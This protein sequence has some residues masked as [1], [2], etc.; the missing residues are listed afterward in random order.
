MLPLNEADAAILTDIVDGTLS[1]PEWDAWLAA[2]PRAAAELALARRVRFFMQELAAASIAVPPGFEA[3]LLARV[4]AD[5]A[6]RDLL[7]LGLTALGRAVLEL[8][9]VA[10]G[11][12]PVPRTPAAH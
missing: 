5:T 8:F 3:R 6:L 11:L 10:F 12:L 9:A 2:R 1:G 7:D 4:H